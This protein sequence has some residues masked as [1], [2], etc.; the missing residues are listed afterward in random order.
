[1]KKYIKYILIGLAVAVLVYC[2]TY[3]NATGALCFGWRWANR[4]PILTP[5]LA[6]KVEP[7][8]GLKV[9][10]SIANGPTVPD[11]HPVVISTPT[12]SSPAPSA[13]P[14]YK[15]PD[16]NIVSGG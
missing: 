6:N 12:D 13:G 2:F 7:E 3:K 5:A 1:M 9:S 15:E 4:K 14:F 8:T 11:E 10:S 16:M